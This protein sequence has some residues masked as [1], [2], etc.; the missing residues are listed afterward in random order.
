MGDSPTKSG[1]DSLLVPCHVGA[2]I[3][4]RRRFPRHPMASCSLYFCFGGRCRE[5]TPSK[6]ATPKTVPSEELD[7]FEA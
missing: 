7:L 5:E 6:S 2:L 3:D 1:G 4:S